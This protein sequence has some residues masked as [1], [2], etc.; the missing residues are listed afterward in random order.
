MWKAMQ[1]CMHGAS[2]LSSWFRALL[3]TKG[4]VACNMHAATLD[5][6]KPEVQ[7]IC[8]AVPDV[9]RCPPIHHHRDAHLAQ[10]L[11]N[12]GLIISVRRYFHC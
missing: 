4:C 12:I 6:R 8:K 5:Q 1:Q 9:H 2:V 10:S 3:L 11:H 7:C